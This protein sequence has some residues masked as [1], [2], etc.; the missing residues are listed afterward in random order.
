[1]QI[2]LANTEAL[3]QLTIALN[4][5]FAAFESLRSPVQARMRR[6]ASG[7]HQWCVS[8][9]A[10]LH[11]LHYISTLG[12]PEELSKPFR[13][14]SSDYSKISVHEHNL[15]GYQ[16]A[17][18][19][20]N[21]DWSFSVGRFAILVGGVGLVILFA[22]PLLN[23][24]LMPIPAYLFLCAFLLSP[25]ALLIFY[26]LSIGRMMHDEVKKIEAIRQEVFEIEG[27]LKS[28]YQPTLE[29]AKAMKLI[30]M[31]QPVN[32]GKTPNETGDVR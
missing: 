28:E 8:L 24:L 25:T 13:S 10:E 19:Q 14:R 5:A 12:W 16:T 4:F 1:M 6:L 30:S 17:F 27:R 26:N 7:A 18:E 2:D 15:R 21:E 9:S 20:S 29:R 23:G 32:T 22:I 3:V 11:D 31:Q